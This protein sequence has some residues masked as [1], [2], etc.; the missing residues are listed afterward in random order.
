[1]ARTSVAHVRTEHYPDEENERRGG[2]PLWIWPLIPLILGALALGLSLRGNDDGQQGTTAA[3]NAPAANNAGQGAGSGGGQGTTANNA[4]GTGSPITDMLVVAN[5]RN[6]ATYVG[7]PASFANVKVQSVVGDRGFWIGPNADQQLF[8]VIDEANV[9]QTE[10]RVQVV[11][12]QTLTLN[13]V[14]QKLPPLDQ[15]P[16]EW[17]LNASNSAALANQ[18]VY[19]HASQ[20]L[21]G[22]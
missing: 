7:R 20:V 1:M 12:G 4:Q 11:A 18:Q 3:P 6:P 19:L 15:A 14:I 21:A 8:V 2:L 22:R 13:G 5:D 10:N 17:G 9:G 16:R